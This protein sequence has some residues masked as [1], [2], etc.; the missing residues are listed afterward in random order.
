MLKIITKRNLFK[1]I[2][3]I[4]IVLIIF[5]F[6]WIPA[7]VENIYDSEFDGGNG[8]YVITIS[9]PPSTK[10][11]MLSFWVDNKSDI[12]SQIHQLSDG[13]SILFVKDE[14]EEVKK[15]DSVQLCLLN[16]IKDNEPCI[17]YANRLFIVER[18]N[19]NNLKTY[20]LTFSDYY[21]ISSCS[22]YE[23][24]NGEREYNND[25]DDVR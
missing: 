1:I 10:K 23:N 4:S 25:C 17:N 9:N 19:I 16:Q 20:R 24:D 5:Y 6:Q 18:E 8:S 21:G 11:R 3:F 12:L 22:V 2:S 14:F 13:E 7:S 15:E